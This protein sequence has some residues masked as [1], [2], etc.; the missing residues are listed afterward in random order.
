MPVREAEVFRGHAVRALYLAAGAVDVAVETGDDELLAASS[1]QWERTLARRTYLTGGMGSHHPTRRSATT[2]SCRRTAPTPRPAPAIASV[3]LA[4][5]LLLATGDPRYADLVERTLYNVVATVAAADGR[6]FFYANTL[7]SA[8]PRPSRRTGINQRARRAGLRAPWFEVSCCPTNVARTLASL[9]RYLAT[10]DDRRRA[11]PPLRADESRRRARLTRRHRLP[12]AGGGHRQR[13][14]GPGP[15]AS[16]CASRVGPGK[17]ST[18]GPPAGQPGYAS[19]R[20]GR[21]TRS[22][23][24]CR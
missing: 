7:H 8:D 5:R 15:R 16:P 6:A 13:A 18:A 20:G 21:A 11:D 17:I 22:G 12:A 24:T 2:S 14:G 23:S 19:S 1:A 9:G 4:W 10:A 3:M